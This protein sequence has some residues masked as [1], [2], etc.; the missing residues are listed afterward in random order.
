MDQRNSQKKINIIELKENENTTCQTLWDIVKAIPRGKLIA[1]N[2]WGT[3]KTFS[4][5]A[6]PNRKGFKPIM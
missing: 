4:T 1:V 3:T 2:A 5:E 6:A